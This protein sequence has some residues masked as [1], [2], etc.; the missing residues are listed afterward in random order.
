MVDLPY[1]DLTDAL[2][3]ADWLELYALLSPDKN[4]SRGD[5]ESALRTASLHELDEFEEIETKILDVFTEIEQRAKSAGDGYPF[6][7]DYQGIL[8][9]RK[10][11]WECFAEYV[12]CLCLSY[13]PLSNTRSAPK[14]FEAVSR[15]ALERYLA[16]RSV[17]FGAPRHDMPS[18]F[19]DAMKD[20]C[21]R[22]GEGEFR[23]QSTL[24][25][26]DDTV[27]LIAWKDFADGHPSKV[28]IFG[29]CG[30]G[31]NW[32]EKLGDLQP[33]EW[34]RQWITG[35]VSPIPLKSFFTP[36]RIDPDRWDFYARKAGILFD[37]CR[38]A[39]WASRH[40]DFDRR[41]I[42]DWTQTFLSR[43]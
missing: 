6:E 7:F 19:E 25:R 11:N 36:Y 29:Q 32:N 15:I 20:L 37:R 18:S 34:L 1:D 30:A 5:L 38:I 33:E 42:I 43:L 28:M 17:G 35:F 10:H 12:F 24:N 4:S 23:L 2:R 8:S 31:R 41:P 22:M 16:G 9:L 3:L 14:L 39:Y 26:Q 13:L 21:G 27:D 40:S